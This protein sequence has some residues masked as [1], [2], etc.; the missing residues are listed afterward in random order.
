MRQ[1]Q[2]RS[3]QEF[4]AEAPAVWM[5]PDWASA[6]DLPVCFAQL[7]GCPDS[8]GIDEHLATGFRESTPF[9][10]DPF[11][12]SIVASPSIA[13]SPSSPQV[14][15]PR[16]LQLTDS[17]SI[18]LSPLSRRPLTTPGE[19]SRSILPVNPSP[20]MFSAQATSRLGCEL[21]EYTIQLQSPP[22]RYHQL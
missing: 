1:G 6:I 19:F 8:V 11:Y 3:G 4:H 15:F 10:P 22:K 16:F 20:T 9:F 21:P 17:T 12:S 13:T 7:P 5:I 2:S 18:K 14:P